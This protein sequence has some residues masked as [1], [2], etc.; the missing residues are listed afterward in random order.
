MDG[1][2]E[3]GDSVTLSLPSSLPSNSVKRSLHF[4]SLSLSLSLFSPFSLNL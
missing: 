3:G 2:G 4:E 1:E